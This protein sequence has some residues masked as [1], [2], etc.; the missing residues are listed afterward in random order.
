MLTNPARILCVGKD[1]GLLRSRCDVLR[2]AGYNAQSVMFVEADGLLRAGQFDLII[3]SAILQDQER[4]HISA[5][6]GSTIP[7]LM[8]KKLVFASELLAQVEQ[9]LLRSKQHSVA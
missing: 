3:L 9:L 7:I 4:E 8:L 5:V 6:V 1:S 2:H